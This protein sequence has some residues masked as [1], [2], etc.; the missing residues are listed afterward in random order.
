MLQEHHGDDL[1]H[2]CATYEPWSADNARTFE[3]YDLMTNSVK[4]MQQPSTSLSE[5]DIYMLVTNITA[6]HLPDK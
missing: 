4:F 1:H 6:V 3:V 5:G 2:L